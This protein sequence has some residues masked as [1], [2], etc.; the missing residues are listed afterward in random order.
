MKKLLLGLVLVTLQLTAFSQKV[1]FIYIQS[2]P[3]QPFY[4]KM[5]EKVYSSSA[6]GYLILSKLHDSSYSFTIGFPQD[7]GPE[8]GFSVTVGK[9][10]HGYLLKNFGEKGWGLYDLQTLSVQYSASGVMKTDTVAKTGNK[11][12]SAFTDMLSKAADD[13]S[14]KDKTV[15]PVKEEKKTETQKT[16]PAIKTEEIKTVNDPVVKKPGI[17][18][19]V[20][21]AALNEN[22]E[23]G[24]PDTVAVKPAG[25]VE[26]KEVKNEAVT[27]RDGEQKETA[28]DEYKLS[29]VTRRSES[30]TTE[31]FGLVFTDD[32]GGGMVD[33]IRLLIPN[34]RPVVDIVKT[35]PKEE[36]KFLEIAPADTVKTVTEQPVKP[37]QEKTVVEKTVIKDTVT[38]QPEA[39]KKCPVIAA[40]S[41]FFS[42]RKK[43]AAEEGDDNMISEARKY[44]KTKCFTT[45]QVKNLG[46]LFLNDEG[47]YKFFDTA[48]DY[49][50]DPE[51]FP[52]LQAELKDEYFIRR[53]KAMLK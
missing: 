37:E 12:V 23:T 7:K 22:K 4:L 14:L 38:V 53:F 39:P 24:K 10:D 13:P 9:K 34:P 20:I 27:I 21:V 52:S 19:T 44:F 50:A 45:Q 31:G 8:L 26:N 35:E 2:E 16:E 11:E 5:Q 30:S 33:T 17:K 6:S 47:K 40:E 41:D 48:Y 18:D 42:L 32:N 1:Y 36:K 15:Q 46:A 51:N 3:R 25:L 49:V 43:M 28:P 29:V